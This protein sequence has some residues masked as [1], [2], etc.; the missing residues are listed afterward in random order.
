MSELIAGTCFVAVDGQRY[1]LV[2]DFAYRNSG[3]TRE[4]KNGADGFHGHKEKPLN[5]MVRMR[6]RNSGAVSLSV[7]NDAVNATIVAELANGKTVI[8][9]NMFRSGEPVTADAEEGE[10]EVTFEGPDV[11]DN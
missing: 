7:L 8:G 6:L 11:R 3:V 4:P 2:G 9:R 5:G 1:P 10:F